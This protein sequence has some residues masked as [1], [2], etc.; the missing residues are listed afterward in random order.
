VPHRSGVRGGFA[1]ALL[2]ASCFGVLPVAGKLAFAEGFEVGPLLAWR[3]G[4]GAAVLA[5]LVALRG[6][7][8]AVS[9]RRRAALFS[10]GALYA[11]NSALYF[12]ALER[13]PATTTSLVFYVFPA[14]VA[15]LGAV[16]LGRPLTPARLCALVL[17]LVGAALTVGFAREGL[18]AAGVALALASAAVVAVYLTLGEVALRGIATLPATVVV[19]SGTAAAFWLFLIAT[20]GAALPPGRTGWA[21]VA[22]MATVSTAL[23]I[24]AMLGSIARVGAGTTAIV[25]TFEPVVTAVLAALFLHEALAARQYAGGALILSGVVLLRLATRVPVGPDV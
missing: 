25:S 17:A 15:V 18:D 20:G 3:F 22:F 9:G 14:F 24:V 8:G 19:L 7:L 6:G 12:L 11:A 2:S 10:L 1:L 4:L 23:S 5:A 21:L 13:I 16:F